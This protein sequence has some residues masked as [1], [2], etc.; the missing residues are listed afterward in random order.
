VPEQMSDLIYALPD[1]QDLDL[2]DLLETFGSRA[3]GVA[4]LLLG[5]P[6][7]I[8][9]PVPSVGAIL[10]VPL[11]LISLHLLLF[12][13]GGRLHTRLRG[14]R[15]PARSIAV[16]KRHVAPYLARAENV[17]RPR[18]GALASRQRLVGLVCLM[19]SVILFLPIPLMNTPP[20]LCL[21][22][23]AWGI[24]QQDGVFVAA[25][26][27]SSAALGLALIL[28]VQGLLMLAA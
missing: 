26:L 6:D 2:G 25:G 11:M 16:L 12:G 23:L 4:L 1:G 28:V 18:W 24:V 17:T 8:P 14:W 20:S 21:V 13:S 27:V 15:L 5:L 7:A 22:L 3:H 10:G 19:L 9:L